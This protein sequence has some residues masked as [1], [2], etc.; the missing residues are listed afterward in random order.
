M[1]RAKADNLQKVIEDYM[2][3]RNYVNTSQ[4]KNTN[5]Q[6]GILNEISKMES[7]SVDLKYYGD[8]SEKEY[9]KQYAM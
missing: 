6:E 1:N 5:I 2:Q 9:L 8:I 3:K 7:H 4:D